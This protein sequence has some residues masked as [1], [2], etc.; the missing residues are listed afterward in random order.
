MLEWNACTLEPNALLRWIECHSSLGGYIAA[1]GTIAAVFSAIWTSRQALRFEG[2]RNSA[3]AR[4]VAFRLTPLAIDI[5]N[6]AKR[7][8]TYAEQSNY[9]L[10]HIHDLDLVRMGLVIT[11]E[12]PKDAFTDAWALPASLAK[13]CIELDA[14]LRQYQRIC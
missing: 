8:L 9:G 11:L 7:A 2:D 12:I 5:D 13:R 4:I 14:S 1:V 10:D 3:R 6:S